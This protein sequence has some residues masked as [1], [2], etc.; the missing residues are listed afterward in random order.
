MISMVFSGLA[1]LVSVA[2]LLIDFRTRRLLRRLEE[3][4]KDPRL[5]LGS[6]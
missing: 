2:S 4:N 6:W 3:S 1:I 5:D